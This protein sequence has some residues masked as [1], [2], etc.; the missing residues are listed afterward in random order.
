[1][2]LERF[3]FGPATVIDDPLGKFH[4]DFGGVYIPPMI[5][6]RL[7]RTILFMLIGVLGFFAGSGFAL[8]LHVIRPQDRTAFGRIS[9]IYHRILLAVAGIHVD[10]RGLQ[11]VPESGGVLLVSNHQSLFDIILL[12]AVIPR[13]FVFVAKAE[14]FKIPFFGWYMR[15]RGDIPLERASL[16]SIKDMKR[17][18]ELVDS[19]RAIHVFPEGTRSRDGQLGSF[20]RGGLSML[21]KVSAPIIPI[22]IQGSYKI[23]PRGRRFLTP[24]NVRI[25]F[26]APFPAS[27]LTDAELVDQLRQR[28]ADLL[29]S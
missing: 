29:R 6:T 28:L 13:Y 14:L 26:D 25:T 10:V 19:G 22:A 23:L 8:I 16:R 7:V 1:M 5:L 18:G 24:Q 9:K 20:K 21:G 12:D 3:R 15:R 4:F 17:V 2:A 27:G 11:Y